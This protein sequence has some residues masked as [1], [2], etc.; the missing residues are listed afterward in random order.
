MDPHEA[1]L[2]PRL[3]LFNFRLHFNSI[4]FCL[5]VTAECTFAF[6]KHVFSL[7]VKFFH[8]L[9]ALRCISA[10][11]WGPSKESLSLLYKA[12]LQ[13]LLTNASLG[14]F[15]FL[16][17]TNITILQRLHQAAS[18]AI[19]GCLSFSISFLLSEASLPTLRVP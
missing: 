6:S 9:K 12:L 7:K 3:L 14:W 8:R 1:N 4:T 5:W 16:N 18:C 11:L 19:T 15:L 10:S 13:P 17:V 2:Q